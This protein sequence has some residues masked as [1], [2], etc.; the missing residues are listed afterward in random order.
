MPAPKKVPVDFL[1]LRSRK[2]RNFSGRY[3]EFSLVAPAGRLRFGE[4]RGSWL[5]SAAPP[6]PQPRPWKP[7]VPPAQVEAHPLIP[8]WAALGGPPGAAPLPAPVWSCSA[9]VW[10]AEPPRGCVAPAGRLRFGDARGSWLG[11]AANLSSPIR[12]S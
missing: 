9:P 4:A 3:P 5:G 12:C 1:T 11:S 2:S 10:S 7:P 6:P 8:R